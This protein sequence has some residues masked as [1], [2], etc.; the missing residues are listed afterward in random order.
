MQS[1]NK[2]LLILLFIC[3][4]G[5]ENQYYYSQQYGTLKM[6]RWARSKNKEEHNASSWEDL[7][8]KKKSGVFSKYN[9]FIRNTFFGFSLGVFLTLSRIFLKNKH[10]LPIYKAIA[11]LL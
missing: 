6:T 7:K 10:F 1:L 11:I 9:F 4:S 3:Y 2:N 8:I 5:I